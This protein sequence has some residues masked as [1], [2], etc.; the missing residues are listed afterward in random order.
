MRTLTLIAFALLTQAAACNPDD[1]TV[2]IAPRPSDAA[3][4]PAPSRSHGP[5]VATDG[6]SIFRYDTFGDETFWTDTLRMHE[7]IAAAVSPATALAVGLKVDANALPDAV[8]SAIRHGTID[9]SSPKTTVALLQLGA[10]LGVVGQVSAEGALTRVGITCAFCHSTVDNSFAPGIGARLDG[11]PNRDLNVGAIISLSPALTPAQKAVYGSW[12]PGMYDP[13]YSI[14]GKNTPVVIPPAFG[15]KHVAREVYTGDGPV[16]YW[17]A[18]VAV[19]QMHG[20]GHFADPRIGVSVSNPPDLV[21]S[22]LEPLSAYQFT[23]DAPAAV[24]GSFDRAAARRGRALFEGAAKCASCHIG[25]SL[26]DVNA[27]RLHAPAEV[28]QDPAYALRSATKHYRTTPLRGL[29]NPPQL[30][31]PYFHDGSARTLGET[32]SHYDRL[33]G[34]SL[35]EHQQRDL[36]EYLKTL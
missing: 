25:G 21:S 35:S 26:S 20:H 12:G 36:V 5:A 10:V 8:K 32:V 4:A 11:W 7:V 18:Y 27:G 1:A 30:K 29:W 15:L 16:S 9:L 33:F 31:G 28:G 24:A 6:Q 23:L 14:D 2:A 3:L 19:T 17:N 13:R 22:K 34:L